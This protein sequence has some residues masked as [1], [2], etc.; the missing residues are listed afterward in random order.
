VFTTV[1]VNFD[2]AAVNNQHLSATNSFTVTVN[3]IH[4]SPTLVAQSNLT[5]N[6]YTLLTV[7]NT[8]GQSSVPPLALTYSLVSPPAGAAI[9]TNGV[10]T[11]TPG[12]GQAPATNVITTIVAD[13]GAPSMGATNSFTVVVNDINLPPV[14]PA[15]SNFTSVGFATIV[16]T[17]TATDPNVPATALNYSLLDGP[18][19]AVIDTNGVITW[20]PVSEQVPGTNVFTTI[21]SNFNPLAVNAQSLSATNSFTVT[22]VAS[23]TVTAS[24]SF[25]P[26]NAT[27]SWTALPGHTYR[28]Q[29]TDNL[30]SPSS[31]Q[32]LS[33][34]I[35][36]SGSIATA[37]DSA[38]N[39][40]Q[41]FYR[42]LFVQ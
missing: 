36:A 34:D 26:G 2:Q 16:V 29:Y 5:V 6:Q 27:I 23:P 41:R 22:V 12:A 35:T 37:T 20:T 1:V 11:W 24:L 13:N 25:A 21:V 33:P 19:N 14:L 3:A 30:G 8:A 39:P 17:N 9:D 7:T 38:P 10:I 31:W 18:S 15:Q 4:N 42:I 32:T 40:T 28:V